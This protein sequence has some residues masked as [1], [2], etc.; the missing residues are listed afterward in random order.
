M[1]FQQRMQGTPGAA[2]E[3]L[4]LGVLLGAWGLTDHK[5]MAWAAKFWEIRFDDLRAG[6]A[7]GFTFLT[8][9]HPVISPLRFSHSE[10]GSSG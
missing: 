2:H 10:N 1:F 4:A 8:G 9:H 3:A 5:D 7:E 6:G